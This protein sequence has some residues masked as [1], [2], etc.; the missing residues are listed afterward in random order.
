M[1]MKH[2]KNNNSHKIF[3]RSNFCAASH[4]F[5]AWTRLTVRRPLYILKVTRT[6]GA[7]ARII[8][9]TEGISVRV[10]TRTECIPVK[11]M[12]ILPQ[13]VCFFRDSC[14]RYICRSNKDAAPASWP[15]SGRA[16]MCKTRRVFLRFDDLLLM[17]VR[18]NHWNPIFLSIEASIWDSEWSKW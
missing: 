17:N 10:M 14:R 11:E 13:P 7:A 18:V 6:E 16:C 3:G 15:F 12:R 8:T 2:A 5:W 1:I 9:R 4:F